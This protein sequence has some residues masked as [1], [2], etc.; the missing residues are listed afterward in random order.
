MFASQRK[1]G[2]HSHLIEFGTSTQRAQPYLR[3]ALTKTRRKQR[4][5]FINRINEGNRRATR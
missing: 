2:Y 1:G 3:P 4:E 5:A